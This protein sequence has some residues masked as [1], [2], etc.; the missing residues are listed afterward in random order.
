MASPMIVN[1]GLYGSPVLGIVSP[2]VGTGV[3]VAAPEVGVAVAAPE[4]GVTAAAQS[5]FVIVLDSS[6]TAPFLASN[7]PWTVAPVLADMDVSA[8]IWPTKC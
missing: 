2:V 5:P 1:I 6:V 4:V 3:A 8:K 7:C